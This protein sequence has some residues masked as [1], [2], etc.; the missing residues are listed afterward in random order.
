MPRKGVWEYAAVAIAA[1]PRRQVPS[2]PLGRGVA[3]NSDSYC[4]KMRKRVE[5]NQAAKSARYVANPTA[6]RRKRRKESATLARYRIF[7]L[8]S[9]GI[10]AS[11][12][13]NRL[14]G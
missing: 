4:P 9:L 2:R 1:L 3:I 13:I 5:R 11:R 14:Q 12:T 8:R 7:R 10:R 6:T